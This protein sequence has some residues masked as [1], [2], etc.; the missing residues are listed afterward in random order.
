MN[1]AFCVHFQCVPSVTFSMSRPSR[2]YFSTFQHNKT[3]T[4]RAFEWY[5]ARLGPVIA[6]VSLPSSCT[7]Q[8]GG[9]SHSGGSRG[10]GGGESAAA[11]GAVFVVVAFHPGGRSGR[12]TV[13]L[14]H[15]ENDARKK[16]SEKKICV[17]VEIV[18]QI[19][20]TSTWTSFKKIVESLCLCWLMMIRWANKQPRIQFFLFMR[21]LSI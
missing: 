17:G 6:H 20:W 2:S 4:Q 21:S 13:P 9:N 3:K 10:G 5:G 7:L 18:D 16:K 12:R 11:P 14:P 1:S 8:W 15:N 19:K